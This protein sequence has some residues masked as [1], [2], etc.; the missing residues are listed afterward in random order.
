MFHQENM[1]LIRR[2]LL[3]RRMIF[4]RK[5]YIRRMFFIKMFPV[6]KWLSRRTFIGS[7]VTIPR[8]LFPRRDENSSSTRMLPVDKKM[9]LS[10]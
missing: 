2:R 8:K 10:R 5:M 6:Q 4:I 7:M 1:F 9:L 3:I